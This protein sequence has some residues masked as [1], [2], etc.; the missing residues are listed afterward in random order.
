MPIKSSEA[1]RVLR[2]LS[3]ATVSIVLSLSLTEALHA[4]VEV[5]E[6]A[7]EAPLA[8]PN[9]PDNDA[10]DPR[11]V[12]CFKPLV[13]QELSFIQRVGSLDEK[14]MNDLVAKATDAY[15]GMA[16]MIGDQNRFFPNEE[17]FYGPSGEMIRGNPYKRVRSDAKRYAEEV[18]SDEQFQ[19]YVREADARA[20][21]ERDTA[22]KFVVDL[23]EK[24]LPL[25]HDQR[26]AIKGNLA[27]DWKAIDVVSLQIYTQNP[28]YIPEIPDAHVL[29]ELTVMQKKIWVTLKKQMANLGSHLS[30]GQQATIKEQWIK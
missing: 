24:K 10:V 1:I 17:M 7:A 13:N 21:F 26:E 20:K 22:I 14:S 2:L 6:M 18:L 16:D 30:Q 25:S 8:E 12:E 23:I 28:R 9:E 11:K 5:V 15:L 27:K 3:N 29:P 4:Q 19:R